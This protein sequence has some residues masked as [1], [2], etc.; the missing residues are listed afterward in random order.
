[1]SDFYKYFKENMDALGLPA[2]ESLFGSVQSTVGTV[3]VLLGSIDKF[4]TKV[5]VGELIGAGTRLEKLGVVAAC[6]AAY[7]A[8]A[9]IGSLAV[10]TGRSLGHGTSLGDVL[11]EA[12]RWGF[13]RPWL[14][15][16]LHRLPGVYDPHVKARKYYKHQAAIR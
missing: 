3:T 2:P 7:Y 4:G 14:A 11:L 16:L 12:A 5:T 1:M 8:G 10:A 13:K 9:V 6:S 15:S